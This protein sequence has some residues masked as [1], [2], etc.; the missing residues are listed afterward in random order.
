[1]TASQ[2]SF[3]KPLNTEQRHAVTTLKQHLRVLAG[4]GSGKTQVL[5]CRIAW[6]IQEEALFP[7]QILAVTFTN[8]AAQEM[9]HRLSSLLEQSH[10]QLWAGTFHSLAHRLLR[11]HW[12]AAGLRQDFQVLDASDQQKRIKRIIR[13]MQLDETRFSPRQVQSFINQQK[14]KG[15][16]SHQVE[17]NGINFAQKTLIQIYQ[18]Y[19]ADCQKEN[20][21]DFSDLLLYSYELFIKHPDILEQYHQRFRHILIDEFQDTSA[22]Q[23]DWIKLMTGHNTYLTIVGDDDQSIYGW[24]GARIE[25]M[26]RFE[27]DFLNSKTVRLEQ[28]YRSTG[29]IL[30]AANALIEHNQERLG[31]NLWTNEGDG[32]PISVYSAVSDLDEARFIIKNIQKALRTGWDYQDIALLYRSNAQ[33]R[34]LEEFLLQE[35]IPY[36]IYGGVRFFERAEIKTALAY[37]RL[38]VSFEDNISF[39][40]VINTPTRG[41]GEKTVGMLREHAHHT[42]HSLYQSGKELLDRKVFSTRAHKSLMLFYQL[43]ETLKETIQGLSIGKQA[44]IILDK[45]GLFDFYQ[46]EGNEQSQ[47]RGENLKELIYA[48][49]QFSDEE[50]TE[51]SLVAF[52]NR[53][54]LEANDYQNDQNSKE[55]NV[56][57][58]TLHAAKGLEF[59]IVF[60]TGLEEGV[61]PSHLATLESNRV[62]EERRLCYVGMT[63]AKKK[64]YLSH[65]KMRRFYGNETYRTP[66][67]FLNEIPEKYVELIQTSQKTSTPT[68]LSQTGTEVVFDENNE[69]QAP[70]KI[71]Q[72]VY[73]P[74]F[75]RG[76]VLNYEGKDAYVRIQVKFES[77]GSKWLVLQFANL[78]TV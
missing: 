61:F 77:H 73:H 69:E 36:R 31:K 68:F 64:L 74:M 27:K 25:N 28:N 7:R 47:M 70:F 57:L 4:A 50:E 65:A 60:L 11:Y 45:S 63:R 37:L 13:S 35:S 26:H 78:Q 52:L 66:S 5:V 38:M 43:I 54:T 21:L 67:R 18:T 8:K 10:N 20:V 33:S 29:T 34:I 24:R 15:L 72:T 53:I 22:M 58:M 49:Y 71:R 46:K 44:E 51:H 30:S 1:M 59:S 41:L 55:T 42:N 12:E 39:E 14:D 17:I 9:G 19:E 3:L 23:Y 48:V 56:Q 75:G 16:R 62:E 40:Q 6:L 2:E 76:T 32:E